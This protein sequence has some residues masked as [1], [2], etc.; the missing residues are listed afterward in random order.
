MFETIRRPVPAEVTEDGDPARHQVTSL[1]ELNQLLDHSVRKA[2]HQQ[3]HSETG[4]TPRQRWETAAPADLPAAGRL[5]EAFGWRVPATGA[6]QNPHRTRTMP[7]IG[8]SWDL[9][10]SEI[11]FAG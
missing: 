8:R 1:D 10:R 5:P 2:C 11:A 6:P 7:P 3:V 4:Q 9:S